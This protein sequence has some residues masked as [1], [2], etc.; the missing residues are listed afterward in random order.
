MKIIRLDCCKAGGESNRK[1]I[2]CLTP[3]CKTAAL[4][5]GWPGSTAAPAQHYRTFR[6]CLQLSMQVL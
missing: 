3:S 1:G 6:L 2:A 5:P 4:L